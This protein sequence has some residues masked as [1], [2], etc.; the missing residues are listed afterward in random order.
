MQSFRFRFRFRFLSLGQTW[1]PHARILRRPKEK[2][3]PHCRFLSSASDLFLVTAAPFS[4][5]TPA[6]HKLKPPPSAVTGL[7]AFSLHYRLVRSMVRSAGPSHSVPLG[8]SEDSSTA[9]TGHGVIICSRPVAINGGRGNRRLLGGR[10]CERGRR[11]PSA[12]VRREVL[13]SS[14]YLMFP[15]LAA[16][17]SYA[18]KAPA[19]VS[20]VS[21]NETRTKRHASTSQWKS[22]GTRTVM[23]ILSPSYAPRG[24]DK[25]QVGNWSAGPALPPPF[26]GRFDDENDVK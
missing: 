26:L 24:R 23:D 1:T 17:D 15:S 2:A 7:G 18:T 21:D 16:F 4:L 14:L 11:P 10:D 19:T 8:E 25:R 3:Y 6:T 5:V 12:N 13:S 9:C 22:L 20:Q